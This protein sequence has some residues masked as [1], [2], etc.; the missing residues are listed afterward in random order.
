MAT[1]P[2]SD[3][4]VTDAD[5][6]QYDSFRPVPC[7]SEA[8]LFLDAIGEPYILVIDGRVYAVRRAQQTRL[9]DGGGTII[10]LGRRLPKNP[11]DS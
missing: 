11:E 4:V 1:F 9:R 8:E 10:R 3:L 6:A 5:G 2:L 7:E